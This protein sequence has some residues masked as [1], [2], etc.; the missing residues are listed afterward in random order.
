MSENENTFDAAGLVAGSAEDVV[1]QLSA[2]NDEE[3]ASVHEAEEAGENR[4]EVI[5]AIAAIQAERAAPDPD[6]VPDGDGMVDLYAPEN[7]GDVSYDG[8]SY[9]CEDGVV[10]VPHAA[11][12]DLKLHGFSTRKPE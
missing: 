8:K 11:V 5:E 1:V 6:P 3:L 2:L 9:P 7:S 10:R 4:P 12:A